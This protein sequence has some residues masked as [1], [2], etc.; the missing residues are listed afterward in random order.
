MLYN[1]TDIVNVTIN[2]FDIT[3]DQTENH[4]S[5]PLKYQTSSVIFLTGKS[6]LWVDFFVLDELYP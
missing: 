3:I 6:I 1:G 4:F 5:L 2:M